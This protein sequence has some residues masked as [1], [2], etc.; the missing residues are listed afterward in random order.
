MRLEKQVNC[1]L[2]YLIAPCCSQQWEAIK[3][4][5]RHMRFEFKKELSGSSAEDGF[6]G[7]KAGGDRPVRRPWE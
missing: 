4:F 2:K 7:S 5:K 1:L 6:E 3:R